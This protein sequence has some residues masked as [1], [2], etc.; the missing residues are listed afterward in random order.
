MLI[1]F[2]YHCEL[3]MKPT[4]FNPFPHVHGENIF[5][6]GR[7]GLRAMLRRVVDLSESL[8]DL[9]EAGLGRLMGATGSGLKSRRL[10][11]KMSAG[12]ESASA[13]LAVLSNAVSYKC[14]TAIKRI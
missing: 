2:K 9:D 10:V 12:S 4:Y 14:R 7:P 3:N 1:Q 5:L 6:R 13:G 8:L 11:S